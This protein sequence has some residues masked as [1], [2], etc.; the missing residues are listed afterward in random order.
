[1][2]MRAGDARLEIAGVGTVELD[3]AYGGM[4]Y[5]IVDATRLGFAVSADEARELAM[6]GEKIRL[7]A[8]QQL[9]VV[10]PENPGIAG[11]ITA[12]TPASLIMF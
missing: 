5:A 3:V 2:I 7:A 1:M 10:H 8:R 9:A 6:L 4:F 12:P 11:R